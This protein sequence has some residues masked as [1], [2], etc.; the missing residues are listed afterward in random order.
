MDDLPQRLDFEHGEERR[1]TVDGA[2]AGERLDRWLVGRLP[3][4]SRAA[5]QRLIRDGRVE[6][7]GS[8]ARPAHRL[9]AGESVAVQV[10]LVLPPGVEPQDLPLRVVLEEPSFVVLDKQAG[11]AVHPGAGRPDGTIANAIAWRYRVPAGAG[12]AWRPGIVH[13][14]D[15]DTSGVMV[16]AR[17]EE[18]HAALADAFQRREVFK[19]YRALVF[20]DPP[21]D[22][23][24]IDLPIGRDAHH[25]T[26][27]AVRF[28]QGREA[29]TDVVV[30]ERFG[31]AAHVRCH[32]LTG[33]THQ[34]RVHCASRGHPL[35]GDSTYARGLTPPVE[36][37][38]LML[39]AH[40]LRFPH[41][42]TGAPVEVEAPLPPD[43]T[44]VADRLRTIDGG[45]ARA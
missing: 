9:R 17:T 25:P 15:L 39:H 4:F 27:M 42:A 35:L 37:P 7:D 23:D 8:A 44:A 33:R 26:R 18:A 5:I 6:V 10:P 13:R 30:E 24:R 34:I 38:R 21:F 41:P 11:M 22:E 16:V 43:F 12:A 29:R 3:D 28:D 20:G 14:L 1:F 40:R 32:P 2:Q 36:V 31:V 19:E 45:A